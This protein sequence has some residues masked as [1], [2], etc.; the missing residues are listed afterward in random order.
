MISLPTN[1]TANNG[2]LINL[3]ACVEKPHDICCALSVKSGGFGAFDH[4][5]SLPLARVS[6]KGTLLKYTDNEYQKWS[7]QQMLT[8]NTREREKSPKVNPT[9]K[10]R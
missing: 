4:H 7:Y 2:F 1:V 5:L 3:D 10:C 8:I 9:L 6:K